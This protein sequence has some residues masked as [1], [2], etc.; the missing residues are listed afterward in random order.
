MPTGPEDRIGSW[1]FA[2]EINIDPHACLMQRI[3]GCTVPAFVQNDLTFQE[4]YRPED[5]FDRLS[6]FINVAVPF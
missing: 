6:E 4:R 2:V 5:T 1:M 3:P